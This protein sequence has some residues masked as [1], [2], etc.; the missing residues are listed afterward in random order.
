MSPEGSPRKPDGL[1]T[2]AAALRK[3]SESFQGDPCVFTLSARPSDPAYLSVVI[4]GQSLTAGPTTYSFDSN[5]NKV[6]FVGA[7][8]TQLNSSTT[9]NPVSVEFRIVERF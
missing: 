6:T 7:L 3:I 4:N 1:T 9:Q 5:S 8:C 2:E